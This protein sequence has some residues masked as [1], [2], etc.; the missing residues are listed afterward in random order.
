MNFNLKF[1]SG[2]LTAALNYYRAN[3][4]LA[5]E[6]TECK[7]DGSDGLFILGQR[8]T[9]VSH[10]AC[11]VM[12]TEYPKL[13]IEVIPNANHFVHQ[14]APEQINSLIRTFLGSPLNYAIEKLA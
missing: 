6:R 8:D 4:S 1:S 7:D 13:E 10:A 9:Y 2:A 11:I 5:T 3:T 12:A 14:D